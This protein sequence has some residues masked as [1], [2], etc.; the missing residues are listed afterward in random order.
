MSLIKRRQAAAESPVE[1]ELVNLP[2]EDMLATPTLVELLCLRK[3]DDGTPRIPGTILLFFEGGKMKA[4]ISDKDA[5][6]VAFT[7]VEGLSTALQEL[8][9]V[10]VSDKLD[11]RPMRPVG[12]K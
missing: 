2:E 3:W 10:L 7:T 8:E 1:D 12:K 9:R 6:L 11:W 4:C 5:K